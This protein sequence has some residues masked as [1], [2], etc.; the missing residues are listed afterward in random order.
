[1]TEGN[2]AKKIIFFALPIFLGSLFQQLYNTI[3]AVVVGN[4]L[5]K[6]ALAAV[7]SSGSLINLLIG[8]IQGIFI[9]AGVVI[10]RRYGA[11]DMEGV[12]RTAHTDLAFALAAGVGLTVVGILFSPQLL[13]WMGTPADVMESSVSYLRWY[14][15]GSLG[16]V[17]YNACSGVFRAV[18]N[19]RHPLYFL[20]TASLTN[21]VLDL[22]LVPPMGVAGAAIATS[23]SQLL[24]AALALWQLTRTEGPIRIRL[25]ELR[26][27]PGC[28]REIVGMGL[29]SGVQNSVIS[30]ANVVVQTNVNA[31]GAEAMAGVGSYNKLEGFVFLPVMSFSMALTTFV[32]QNL[33]ARQYDRAR[34]GARFGVS[35][36]VVVSVLVGVAMLLWGRP[37]LAMFDSDPAVLDYGMA[38]N[39]I[40]AG[41]YA[42][43]ALSHTMAAVLRGAGKAKVPM[44]IMLLC[45]CLIRV[46]YITVAVRFIP[47]IRV[48]FWAY[49][50]TWCLSSVLFLLYY[51]R[52]D[53]VHGHERAGDNLSRTS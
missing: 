38:A 8:L 50:L 17:L 43:L 39:R 30:F 53:W 6:Q 40:R 14:F 47:D 4:V 22:L 5:G 52:G 20:I 36:C 32:S 42:V 44:V 29:P 13:V 51:F 28:L 24:S 21:V 25:S 49:P 2:I 35:S 37:L 15:A 45:W 23:I 41:F 16:T 9:G 46:S 19:S 12:R 7:T 1:M 27:H 26:F 48:V 10:A 33:G 3:D 11:Q 18:G 31:F 34:Q